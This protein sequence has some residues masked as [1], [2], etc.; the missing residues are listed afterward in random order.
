MVGVIVKEK[1]YIIFLVKG[2]YW[3]FIFLKII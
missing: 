3:D 2:N 1:F